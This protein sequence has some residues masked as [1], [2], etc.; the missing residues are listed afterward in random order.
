[1]S[2]SRIAPIRPS[3]AKILKRKI[4]GFV[5]E[6]EREVNRGAEPPKQPEAEKASET[7]PPA[8]KPARPE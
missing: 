2:D 5:R 8:D 7:P 1:M 3:I 6:Y 4:G